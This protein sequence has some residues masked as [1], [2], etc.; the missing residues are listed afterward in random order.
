MN[1]NMENDNDIQI[2]TENEFRRF[3]NFDFEGRGCERN[4]RF[5]C[6]F[7]E[8]WECGRNDGRWDCCPPDR[9]GWPTAADFRRPFQRRPDRNMTLNIFNVCRRPAPIARVNVF[10]FCG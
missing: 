2:M 4:N 5:E 3:S 7:S 8:R 9:R 10:N 6:G 1:I